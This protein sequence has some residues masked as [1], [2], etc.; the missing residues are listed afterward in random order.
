MKISFM[1]KI[2]KQLFGIIAMFLTIAITGA[3]NS[4]SHIKAP[5]TTENISRAVDSSRWVFTANVAMPQYGGSKQI[6][7]YYSVI[8]NNKKLT[9]Y[10]PYY[11]RAYSGADVTTDRGPLDFTS[12][13]FSFDK[14][15]AKRGGWNIMIKPR[16]HREV[17]SMNFTFY[18]NGSADLS[19]NM[20]NRSP[21]SFTG[22]VGPS[23]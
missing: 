4:A 16:D 20:S 18:D 8:Y 9:V 3:C 12:V 5:P 21:I 7:G 2:I 22:N 11:G 6:P 14:Q 1:K 15:P 23:K 10:L 13:D 17:Q 19:V